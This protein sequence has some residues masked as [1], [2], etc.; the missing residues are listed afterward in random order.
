MFDSG[1]Y[2]PGAEQDP[3]AP[4]KEGELP[5]K[6]FNVFINQVLSKE[7]TVSTNDYIPE[8]DF[9][10]TKETNWYEAYEKEHYTP[11]QLIKLFKTYLTE[12]MPD[13]VTFPKEHKTYKHLISECEDWIEDETEINEL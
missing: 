12:H 11:L 10:N 5:E 8:E 7:I 6:T 13:A 2:P 3:N 4:W 9:D 1:Y